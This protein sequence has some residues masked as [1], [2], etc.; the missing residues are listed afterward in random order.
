M[1]LPGQSTATREWRLRSSL[2]LLLVVAT[3][4]TFGLVSFAALAYR[5]PIILEQDRQRVRAEAIELAHHFER[6]IDGLEG[7]LGALTALS[8]EMPP[9]S[10]Q[11]FLD[12]AAAEGGFK[13]I[14]LVGEHGRGGYAAVAEDSAAVRAAMRARPRRRGGFIAN[15][16]SGAIR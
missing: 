7:R 12:A 15:A 9:A 2:M 10:I 16:G 5:V 14:Y 6:L 13:A 8:L 11:R 4:G 1:T 3:V